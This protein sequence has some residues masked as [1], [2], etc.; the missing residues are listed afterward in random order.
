[1]GGCLDGGELGCY[2]FPHV[3]R[4]LQ[5]HLISKT[6]KGSS[7]VAFKSE[8]STGHSCH[9]YCITTPKCGDASLGTLYRVYLAGEDWCGSQGVKSTMQCELDE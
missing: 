7:P 8:M 2:C 3:I 4:V 6:S 1:V 5:C 9:Q